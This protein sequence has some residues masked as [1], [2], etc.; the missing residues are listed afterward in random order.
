MS[1]AHLVA[2]FAVAAFAL[3]LP[4]GDM[5]D[6]RVRYEDMRRILAGE[7]TGEKYSMVGPL[8]A[9][10]LHYVGGWLGDAHT[11]VWAFNRL[12]LLAGAAGFWWLLRPFLA[13]RTRAWFVVALL[14]TSMVPHHLMHFGGEPFSALLSAFGLAATVLRRAWWGLPLAVVGA[15]NTPGTV[16]GLGVATLVLFA[17]TRRLRHLIAA[18]LAAGLVLLENYVRRGDPFFTGYDGERG[19]PNP[20]PYAGRPEFSYPLFFGVL[21]LLFSFGKGLV[22]FC[23]AL[24]VPNP[25]ADPDRDAAREAEL[26]WVY[27]VWVG[28]VVGLLLLYGRWWAWYGG[29][30]WGPRFLLLA[31]FPA[32]LVLA[33]RLE[34][35][36]RLGTGANL[37]TLAA[38]ALACWAGVNGVVYDQSGVIHYLA[39]GYT[40]EFVVWYVPECSALWWPWVFPKEL[41]SDD[42]VRLAGGLAAFAYLSAPLLAVLWRRL[43]GHLADLWAAVRSGPRIRP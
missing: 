22:Y 40:L 18:P 8:C 38:L 12:L 10:P 30:F 26:R 16:V 9:A 37:L 21:S 3:A 4:V 33:R 31:C 23:P 7:P 14:A 29:W 39:E 42:L 20:L 13:A 41:A 2:L 11:A 1:P 28:Y 25:P 6:A 32:A 43:P 24:F 15:V 35:A 17:R 34:A 27:R 19:W 36:G 5:H